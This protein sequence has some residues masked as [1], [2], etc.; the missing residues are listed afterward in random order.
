MAMLARVYVSNS[1]DIRVLRERL[2]PMTPELAFSPL[3]RDRR[4]TARTPPF[5]RPSINVKSSSVSFLFR[6]R[7]WSNFIAPPCCRFYGYPPDVAV[8]LSLTRSEQ[9]ARFRC[10]E[11]SV[12]AGTRVCRDIL[13]IY[14][15]IPSAV[16]EVH[17]HCVCKCTWHRRRIFM[18]FNVSWCESAV[19]IFCLEAFSI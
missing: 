11:V 10:K 2:Q 7:A 14:C 16:K 9:I 13:L 5:L 19:R 1:A 6:V 4:S 17:A 8:S 18:Y 12:W 15:G 3:L